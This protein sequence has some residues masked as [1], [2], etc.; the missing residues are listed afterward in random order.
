MKICVRLIP[1]ILLINFSSQ[2][3]AEPVL[4]NSNQSP[5]SQLSVGF[6]ASEIEY[7][8]D[9]IDIDI[10]RST[11]VLNYMSELDT[12]MSYYGEFG[13]IMDADI[14]EMDNEDDGRGFQV[15]GGVDA[16]VHKADKFDISVGGGLS[17]LKESYGLDLVVGDDNLDIRVFEIFGHVKSVFK[18]SPK[19]QPFAAVEL[20][21]FSDGKAEIGNNDEDIDREG[22]LNLA[23]GAKVK[24]NNFNIVAGAK[25]FNESTIGIM[26][27]FVF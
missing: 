23:L 22:L 11:L 15:A 3:K 13:F 24:L 2:I 4:I 27:E 14:D 5:E 9:P 6:V 12:D 19:V 20:I 10:E 7:D 1:L 25:I 17:F 21:P 18:I 26:A 16:I 8:V